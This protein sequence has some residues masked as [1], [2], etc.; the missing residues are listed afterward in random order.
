MSI[1]AS[2]SRAEYMGL[3]QFVS[4][5]WLSEQFN[6]ERLPS[7]V[8]AERAVYSVASFRVVILIGFEIGVGVIDCD[9]SAVQD[10]MFWINACSTQG[11]S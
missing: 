7:T 9:G 2:G 5:R 10:W 1:G 8:A 3:W 11:T 6:M 4:N